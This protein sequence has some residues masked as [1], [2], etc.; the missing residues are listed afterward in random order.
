MFNRMEAV[1]LWGES[2]RTLHAALAKDGLAHVRDMNA[3]PLREFC[4]RA[5]AAAKEAVANS[6]D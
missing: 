5:F 3:A 6:E 2:D 4:K 1:G